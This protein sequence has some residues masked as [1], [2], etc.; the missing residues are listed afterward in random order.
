MKYI[1]PEELVTALRAYLE[2]R[3]YSEVVAG[4]QALS[5][6]EPMPEPASEPEKK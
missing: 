1:I 5:T 4:I 2:T 3:P 6:L